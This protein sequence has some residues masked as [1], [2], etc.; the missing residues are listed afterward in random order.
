MEKAALPFVSHFRDRHG[1]VRWRYRKDGVNVPLG[2]D[3]GSPEFLRRLKVAKTTKPKPTGEAPRKVHSGSTSGSLAWAID[4]W[5]TSAEVRKLAEITAY[6]YRQ[7]AERLR[8]EHGDKRVSDLERRHIKNLM[9]DRGDKP[10]A[11]NWVLR[12]LRLVLEH[13]VEI[14]ALKVNPAVGIKRNPLN[15]DGFHTWTEAEIE[16]FYV[17]HTPGTT[18]YTAMTLMLYTGAARADAVRLG[19]ANLQDGRI[20]YR[21]KKMKG[22]AGVL[23]DIPVHPVLQECLDNLPPGQPTFLQTQHK[24]ER[25]PSGL[26]T[27]MREWCNAAGLPECASH[28]LRKACARRVIEAGATSH[29]LMAV[30]GHK[31]LAEA[32][33]YA[34]TFSRAEAADRAFARMG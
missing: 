24:T 26:G 22:R 20:S 31:T 8:K 15:P 2:S 27:Q 32:Q 19:P 4:S 10:A 23:V 12:I 16:K 1:K 3:Y 34:D 9:A 5:Y 6:Q 17:H 30:T 7:V 33:R 18:A 29:E 25:S 21:R 28:G 14:N 13:C 11:A